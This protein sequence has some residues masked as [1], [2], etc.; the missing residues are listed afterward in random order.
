MS[1]KIIGISGRKQSGKNSSANHLNGVILQQRGVVSDFNMLETG[2]LNVLTKFEN[3]KEDW[4]VLDL[5]RKDYAFLEAA[6]NRIFPFVK[7]YSFADSLKEA[8]INLF[9]LKPSSAYGTDAQKMETTHLRWEDMPGVITP[10]TINAN[11]DNL[12]CDGAEEIHQDIANGLGLILH[13][14]GMMTGREFLQFF[15]TEIGR[16]MHCPIWVNATINK[17]KAEQSGLAIVTDVRFPDEVQAIK[18]AGGYVIRLDR[19]ML[20]DDHPSEVALDADV[21]DWG[22]FDAVISNQDL[23]L[24]DACALV[25]KFARSNYLI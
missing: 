20:Q 2:E 7:N 4:G 3:G 14:E 16:K 6:E 1:C 18:D 12:L 15:G 25:E 17:I 19:E 22:N 21:Y 11:S 23:A 24:T 8:A 5:C 9:E 10:S 13:S